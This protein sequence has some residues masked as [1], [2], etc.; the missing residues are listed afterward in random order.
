MNPWS[1]IFTPKNFK[2][3]LST[4]VKWPSGNTPL[5]TVGWEISKLAKRGDVRFSIKM[6]GGGVGKKGEF[7]KKGETHDFS[8]CFEY[9]RLE[10]FFL[11]NRHWNNNFKTC[12]GAKIQHFSGNLPLDPH[13]DS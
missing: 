10:T 3:I 5:L 1:S 11:N 9:S 2:P 7:S 8:D 6:G 12:A 4:I 13:E